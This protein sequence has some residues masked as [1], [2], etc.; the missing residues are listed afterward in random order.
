MRERLSETN[1]VRELIQEISEGNPGALSVFARLAAEFEFDKDDDRNYLCTV[2]RDLDDMNI[3]GSQI[4]IGLQDFAKG[5][6]ARLL[7]AI[8]IRCPSLVA[9]INASNESTEVAVRSGT[10]FARG[11]Y[12]ELERWRD[13]EAAAAAAD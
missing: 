9:C 8:E 4:W 11:D 12:T 1:D 5:D 3:R 2:I 10:C 7:R 6:Y 13:R